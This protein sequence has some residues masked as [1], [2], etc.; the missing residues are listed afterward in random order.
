MNDS[1]PEGNP[2]FFWKDGEVT[3][4]LVQPMLTD[5]DGSERRA[6]IWIV[7]NESDA[8]ALLTN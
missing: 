1:S 3:I 8:D 6:T 4:H 7:V 2:S 5:A